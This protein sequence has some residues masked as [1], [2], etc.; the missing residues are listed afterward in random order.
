[1]PYC[2]KCAHPNPDGSNFC[3]SCGS[4]L[5]EQVKQSSILRGVHIPPAQRVKALVSLIAVALIVVLLVVV[6]PRYREYNTAVKLLASAREEQ[7][8]GKYQDALNSLDQTNSLWQTS[9][10]RQDIQHARELD[11]KYLS[12]QQSLDEARAK[13]AAGDLDSAKATLL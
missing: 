12:Y 11:A 4:A 1:M 7:D 2:S 10:L 3:Q 13:E 6:I 5:T 8:A 9:G